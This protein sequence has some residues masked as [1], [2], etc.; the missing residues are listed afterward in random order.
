MLASLLPTC[1]LA[2]DE[3]TD[4]EIAELIQQLGDPDY[5][6]RDQAQEKLGKMGAR[7]YDALTVAANDRDLEIAARA[8]YLLHSVELPL[9]RDTDCELVRQALEGY[10]EL[11]TPEQLY[12]ICVLLVLPHGEGYRA[13][14]RLAHIENSVVMSKYIATT[15][16]GRWP[17]HAESQARMCDAVEA[18]L[19]HSGRIAAHWLTTY[20]RLVTDPKSGVTAWRKLV[21]EEESLFQE[22]SPK[23]AGQIVAAML[24]DLAHWETQIGAAD[25]AREHFDRAQQVKLVPTESTASFYIDVANFFQNRG[26]FDWAVETYEQASK[27]GVARAIPYVQTG[28]AEML[29]DTGRNEEAAAAM[30]VILGA[31]N[32][33]ELR[34]LQSTDQSVEKVRGRKHFF[35]AC[36]ARDGGDDATYRAELFQAIKDD[37]NELDALI[38]LYRVPDQDETARKNTIAMIEAAT[39]LLRQQVAASPEEAALHNQFAWIVGNTTGDMQEALEHARR[40]VE[41]RPESGAYFDTLAHVYFYGL[42]DYQKAVEA[43][44]KAVEFLPHSGLI[45]QKY[46]LFQKAASEQKPSETT[47]EVPAVP[48]AP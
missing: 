44:A 45:R 26:Q 3:P 31:V 25:L 43:Q 12:Q 46:E 4:Q 23:S 40:A 19:K 37:P 16:L 6:V 27:L 33:Q 35:L 14:C 15:I 28:L 39:E 2:A 10:A 13:A 8:R 20:A 29:H 36:S 18:E 11:S 21:E 48:S 42:K 47:E 30:D 24:Y 9:I 41:L 32:A 5:L 38:A 34:N 1:V 7:A 17:V 22:R